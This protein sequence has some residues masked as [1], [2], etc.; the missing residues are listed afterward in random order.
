MNNTAT[1]SGG[2]I[3]SDFVSGFQCIIQFITPASNYSTDVIQDV[4]KLKDLNFD[5]QFVDNTAMDGNS[6]FAQPL[7]DC[8]WYSESVVQIPS[9]RVDS[10]YEELFHFTVDGQKMQHTSEMRSYPYKPCFCHNETLLLDESGSNCS[11]EHLSV[12]TYPGRSFTMHI[13]AAD[14]LGRSLGTLIQTLISEKQRETVTFQSGS[15]QRLLIHEIL[16]NKCSHLKYTLYST[17]NI[18]AKLNFSIPNTGSQTVEA[19]INLQTCPLGFEVNPDRGLCECVPVFSNH[20]IVCDIETGTFTKNETIWIGPTD[21]TDPAVPAYATRCPEG[22]CKQETVVLL[23]ETNS[24]SQTDRC[25]GNR[26]GEI[27]GKCIQGYSMQFGTTNCYANC[28][29]YYLFTVPMYMIAGLLLVFLLFLLK[30]STASGTLIVVLYYA[31]LISI[32][33]GLL[34]QTDETRFAHVFISLLNLELGF[35]LCFYEGMSFIGKHG[36]QFVFPVYL[37]L[38]VALLTFLSR[39]STRVSNLIGSEC[40]KVFVTLMYLSYTKILRTAFSALVPTFIRTD[41]QSYNVWFFDGTEK[42]LS[43]NHLYLAIMS[44]IFLVFIIAPYKIFLFSAQWMLRSSWISSRYKPLIDAS[45]APFKDRYRFWFGLRLMIIAVLV[46][47][48]IFFTP[49]YPDVVTYVHLVI[50]FILTLIQAYIKPYKSKV[51]NILDIFFLVNYSLFLIGCLFVFS[52]IFGSVID[53]LLPYI[54]AVELLAI[55]TAFIVFVG[56]VIYH[57]VERVRSHHKMSFDL[58]PSETV[59]NKAKPKAIDPVTLN[60][61]SNLNLREQNLSSISAK[62]NML[63]EPLLEDDEY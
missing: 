54:A 60:R 44:I 33:L 22:Y 37:W 38:L 58:G 11:F 50:I 20:D 26:T 34:I 8:K 43:G 16:G 17:D 15:Q 31:Q 28:S 39:F 6:V 12:D 30:L 18:T 2:A 19:E 4:S 7:Y 5:I 13:I 23:N 52:G 62:M 56:V 51:V 59:V 46:V 14:S 55:G 40:I 9:D 49:S 10:V 61:E 41:E 32:N 48:A 1:T 25:Q 21:F 3:Y 57:I 53:G 63:R 42:F 27:C 47:V 36:L 35:P 45:L 24:I 29:N